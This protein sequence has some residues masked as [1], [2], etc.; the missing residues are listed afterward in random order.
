MSDNFR[1]EFRKVL[2]CLSIV[3]KSVSM[4]SALN[5]ASVATMKSTG[6]G[7]G[8]QQ[9]NKQL[10]NGMLLSSTRKSIS[11]TSPTKSAGLNNHHHQQATMAA[12]AANESNK[13]VTVEIVSPQPAEH[14]KTDDANE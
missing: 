5:E 9:L 6:G 13:T 14:Q 4:H 8:K 2:F 11:S 10:S 3:N 1:K 12:M 7:G